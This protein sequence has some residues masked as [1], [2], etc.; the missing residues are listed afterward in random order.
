MDTLQDIGL[1]AKMAAICSLS[2]NYGNV[3]VSYDAEEEAED[4][5]PG[6]GAV[7][8]TVSQGQTNL[9][10]SRQRVWRALGL[11]AALARATTDGEALAG[12]R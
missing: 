7:W 11:D 10:S 5:Y 2:G 8:R 9:A 1:G 12:V 3:G 6:P 4:I